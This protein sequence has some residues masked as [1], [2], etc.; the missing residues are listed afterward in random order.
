MIAGMAWSSV[1]VWGVLPSAFIVKIPM[2]SPVEI[3]F[4][5]VQSYLSA[6]YAD[7]L[8]VGLTDGTQEEIAAVLDAKSLKIEAVSSAWGG[9][10]LQ[11]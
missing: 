7:E 2:N 5:K 11:G 1:T 8:S 10:I 3:N 4:A 6:F 9:P